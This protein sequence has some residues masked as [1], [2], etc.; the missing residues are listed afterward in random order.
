MALKIGQKHSFKVI[1]WLMELDNPAKLNAIPN[2]QK[3]FI[4]KYLLK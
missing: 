4:I 3:Y 1:Y 2:A